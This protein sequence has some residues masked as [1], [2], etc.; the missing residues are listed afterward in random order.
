MATNS[1]FTSSEVGEVLEMGV[2]WVARVVHR[3]P[4]KA[5][6]EVLVVF[7]F[8]LLLFWLTFAFFFSFFLLLLLLFLSLSLLGRCCCPGSAFKLLLLL[9]LRLSVTAA[10]LAAIWAGSPFKLESQS[11]TAARFRSTSAPRFTLEW[12]STEL[13]LLNPSQS[14]PGWLF[15]S[16]VWRMR[17]ERGA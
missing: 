4:R 17:L 5:K 2:K 13:V 8:L 15:S 6:L 1:G 7:L 16:R 9:L 12:R 11:L 3:V 10:S 14:G